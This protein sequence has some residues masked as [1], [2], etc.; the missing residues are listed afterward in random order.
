M[1]Q[2]VI[3][4]AFVALLSAAIIGLALTWRLFTLLKAREPNAYKS[5]GE[6]R[7]IWNNTLSHSLKFVRF[8]F[9]RHYRSLDDEVA[10]K[11]GSFLYAY[12]WAY[13]LCF[14]IFV[15]VMLVSLRAGI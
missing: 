7:L 8:I 14:V 3:L 10:R 5:L 12:S 9:G 1:A 15:I 13:L 6:P 4:P 2:T 11:L